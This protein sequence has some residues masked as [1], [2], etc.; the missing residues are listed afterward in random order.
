M[1]NILHIASMENNPCCGVAVVVPQHIIVQQNL[2]DVV[3][4]NLR[5]GEYAGIENQYF[6]HNI[7]DLHKVILKFGK[8]NLVVFH[9]CYRPKYLLI[10]LVLRKNHI[11][12]IIVP[13][14]ELTIE[15]QNNKKSFK[16]KIANFLLFN[17]FINHALAIQCLSENE[18]NSTIFGHQKFLSTNGMNLSIKFKK[19]FNEKIIKIVFIGRLDI[20]HKGL[21]LLL[22]AVKNKYD[23]LIHNNIK[24]YLYGSD[25]Q[26][27]SVKIE[28]LINSKDLQNIVRLNHEVLNEEK[29]RILL[30]ADVFIQTSRFEGMPMG[31][32]EALSYGLPCLV[33]R[34]TSLGE[35][36]EKYDAGWVCETN[37]DSIAECIVNSVNQK[38]LFYE[39]GL[40]A[41]KLI[42]QNFTWNKV[43]RETI[44][45]YK[46][47]I[48]KNIKRN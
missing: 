41:R 28:Q 33:T 16:K 43:A 14:C 47:L 30:D 17:H 36:I 48:S 20:F 45:I 19:V 18:M 9:E 31:I 4:L 8:P 10:S 38:E 2:A 27:Q 32:L 34:G 29:E 15:A 26:G 6:Y 35:L 13:H 25:Y 22:E 7:F 5:D 44:N 1:M 21:D 12:Y 24:L 42:A 23:Y 46:K 37:V 11:P 3:L 40:N 39:K